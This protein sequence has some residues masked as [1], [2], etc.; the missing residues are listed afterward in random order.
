M[1]ASSPQRIQNDQ[2]FI[3]FVEQ[4]QKKCE[5]KKVQKQ[6]VDQFAGII[7]KTPRPNL[8]KAVAKSLEGLVKTM[9]K[10]KAIIESAAGAVPYQKLIQTIDHLS[11]YLKEEKEKKEKVTSKDNEGLPKR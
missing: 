6:D 2:D 5:E 3:H 7:S 1:S 4:F 10:N 9:D 11:L 8:S